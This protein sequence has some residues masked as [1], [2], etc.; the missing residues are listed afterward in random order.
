MASGGITSCHL[1][2]HFSNEAQLSSHR[3]QVLDVLT[4]LGNCRGLRNLSVNFAAL[5]AQLSRVLNKGTLTALTL[6]MDH[7]GP[8]QAL[9]DA[10]L[11]AAFSGLHNCGRLQSLTIRH[12]AIAPAAL[13]E[14]V[15]ARLAG[16]QSIQELAI[17][18]D[19]PLHGGEPHIGALATSFELLNTCGGLRTFRL[20]CP[21]A[22]SPARVA[23]EQLYALGKDSDHARASASVRLASALRVSP[24]RR[25]F[26]NGLVMHGATALGLA[27]GLGGNASLEELDL[28]GCGFPLNHAP[29]FIRNLEANESIRLMA[30]PAPQS[31]IFHA[32]SD[33]S[34]CDLMQRGNTWDV[35]AC[36]D[37]AKKD[38][39]A[40]EGGGADYAQ[41]FAYLACAKV[42]H[43]NAQLR[44]RR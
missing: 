43:R 44:S 2:P 12:G 15:L 4:A 1:L 19:L 34:L 41:N 11:A 17:R 18:S 10:E 30:M 14:H 6:D 35:D 16:N 23:R 24:L 27:C 31:M 3:R 39:E 32:E 22:A 5:G 28:S 38:F 8:L 13:N 21:A 29:Q 33:G 42:A 25:L 20:E 26:I 36:A 37:S 9:D 7:F 40:F